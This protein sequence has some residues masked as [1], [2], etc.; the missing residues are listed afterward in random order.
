MPPNGSG[1]AGISNSLQTFGAV[2]QGH[3]GPR[4]TYCGP[5]AT[6]QVICQTY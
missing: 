1:V 5:T 2:L 4:M 3:E 6:G